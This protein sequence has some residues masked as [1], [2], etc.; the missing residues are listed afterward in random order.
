M[1]VAVC[2]CSEVLIVHVAPCVTLHLLLVVLWQQVERL[3]MA[4]VRLAACAGAILS[5]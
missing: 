1:T 2:S 3:V 5:L 4:A